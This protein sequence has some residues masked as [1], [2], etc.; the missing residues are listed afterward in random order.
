MQDVE[1]F[2]R[3]YYEMLKK[4]SVTALREFVKT[5]AKSY[6]PEFLVAFEVA[7]DEVVEATLHKMI[8]NA[9]NLPKE[10]RHESALWLI[11]RGYSLP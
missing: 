8:V 9:V 1:K 2:V 3:E 11:A 7:P 6:T 5:H 10:L 4:R